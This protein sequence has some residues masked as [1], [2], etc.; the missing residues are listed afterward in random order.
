MIKTVDTHEVTISFVQEIYD[1]KNE[2]TEIHEKY[3][4]DKGHQKIK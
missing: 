4:T 2:L 3:P 1:T